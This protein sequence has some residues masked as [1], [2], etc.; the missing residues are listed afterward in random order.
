MP[1]VKDKRRVGDF[2]TRKARAEKYPARS[3]YKLE[4]I[5]RK[6][7][8]LKPEARV[9]DLGA[10]PG[11][12]MKYAGQRIGPKGIVVGVDI[13]KIQIELEG[14]MAFISGDVFDPEVRKGLTQNL[15]PRPD[16]KAFDVV[17]SDLAP[18]TTG[19]KGVDQARSLNLA[20]A[21]FG[22]SRDLLTTGGAFLVKVFQGP[23]L[24]ALF[25]DLESS[26]EVVRRIKPKSSRKISPELFGLGLGFKGTGDINAINASGG[27]SV[28]T[29]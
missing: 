21:A 26:F 8:I 13:H 25:T 5:D 20:E 4:E 22:I 2:W 19:N 17:L 7:H 27:S 23:D 12:W 10:A 14:N 29:Q 6:Y 11:A 28:R 9:L 24:N 3:V 16:G 15:Q 1:K 18:A